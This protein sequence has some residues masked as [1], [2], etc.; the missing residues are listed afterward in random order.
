VAL[1]VD[2]DDAEVEGIEGLPPLLRRVAEVVLE[3]ALPGPSASH[4]LG[5]VADGSV[6]RTVR[7]SYGSERARISTGTSAPSARRARCW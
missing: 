4:A 3:V 5:D 6:T 7:P 1:G 2:E